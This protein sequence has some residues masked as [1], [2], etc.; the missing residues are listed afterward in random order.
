MYICV[1]YANGVKW[2]KP[3]R[4]ERFNIKE[5]IAPTQPYGRAISTLYRG[6]GKEKMKTRRLCI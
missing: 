3:R 1:A 6:E 5:E 2:V 4:Q